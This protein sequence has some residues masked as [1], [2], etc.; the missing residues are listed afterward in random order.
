MRVTPSTD[1]FVL[2]DVWNEY[3]ENYFP[4]Y[5]VDTS[6]LRLV[7]DLELFIAPKLY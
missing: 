7:I 4:L 5:S 2:V 1:E 6:L 3:F